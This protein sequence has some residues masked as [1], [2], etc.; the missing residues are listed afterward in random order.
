MCTATSAS[1][2]FP[3]LPDQFCGVLYTL[4]CCLLRARWRPLHRLYTERSLCW[5]NKYV[6]TCGIADAPQ[7]RFNVLAFH[8]VTTT[9]LYYL[10]FCVCMHCWSTL[11]A[12]FSTLAA[13]Y[14]RLNYLY[15]VCTASAPF[16]D[17]SSLAAQHG[18]PN[19]GLRCNNLPTPYPESVRWTHPKVVYYRC[20]RR[21]TAQ[22]P[23]MG[24]D[25]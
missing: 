13:Q 8:L 10:H 1:R 25:I 19:D 21:S 3:T 22:R 11:H 20:S 7:A 14:I 18:R 4:S 12:G 15:P 5:P 24:I 9:T 17:S 23:Y 2:S 6:R 16:M